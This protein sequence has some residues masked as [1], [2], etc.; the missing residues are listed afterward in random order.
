MF[1]PTCGRSTADELKFCPS[2][3]T[4]LEAVTK[5]LRGSSESI[6]LRLNRSCDKFI[7]RYAA[8]FF[9]DAPAKALDQQV[10]NSWK[11]FRQGII[12]SLINLSLLL[13]MI[14]ALPLRFLGLLVYTPFGL[15][16]E[17]SKR[18]KIVSAGRQ[19]KMESKPQGALPEGWMNHSV[20]SVAEH[21][22]VHLGDSDSAEQNIKS[23]L[24]LTR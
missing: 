7:A 16:S 17:R 8:H 23:K 14:I 6:F 12:T 18:L 22:T 20:P 2:C 4:N 15:L 21:T 11:I 13:V 3:G 1:C 19:D 9:E 24:H 5:A 10:N